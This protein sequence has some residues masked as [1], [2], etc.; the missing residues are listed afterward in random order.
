MYKL[1]IVEDEPLERQALRVILQ[2]NFF[3]IE[4]KTDSTN[5]DEAILNAKIFR[6]DIILM[7]IKMPEKTGLD[8]QKEIINFLPNVKTII[9]TAYE[10]FEYAQKS[11][12]YGAMDYL[13]KPVRPVDLRASVEKA[14]K[15]IDKIDSQ[16]IISLKSQEVSGDVIKATLKYINNN[17]NQQISLESVAEFVHLNSQY[18]SRYFKQ[19]VGIT[20][21]QYIKNLRI[22]NAKKLLTRSSKSI[23]QISLEVGYFDAA[24]FSKVFSSQEKQSPYK[25]RTCHSGNR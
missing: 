19:K 23:T 20:F 8:A 9:M 21:T 5:G 18:L 17:Y 7:D 13:L 16:N 25:F 3:N 22:E 1:M 12:K 2:R 4:I 14:I 11:I 10:K 15:S 24:Y 6:P